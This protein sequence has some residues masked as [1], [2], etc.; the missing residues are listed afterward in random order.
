MRTE[1][2]VR[3]IDSSVLA[4]LATADE[5]NQ[6]SVSPKE[7]FCLSDDRRSILIAN[8]ASPNSKKNV[9]HNPK[10]CVSFVDIFVQKGLKVYGVARVVQEKDVDFAELKRPLYEMA[11][12]A[13]PFNSLFEVVIKEVQPIL[14]PRYILYPE[15]T[16]EDQIASARKVYGLVP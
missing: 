4:W 8:I 14:A 13:F 5:H 3:Y 15:T 1:D 6:P 16:E 12:G 11:G 10:V 7:I 9:L 2:L